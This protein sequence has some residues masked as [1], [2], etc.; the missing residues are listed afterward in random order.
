MKLI[1]LNPLILAVAAVIA[2]QANGAVIASSNF[3]GL[4]VSG[5]NSVAISGVNGFSWTRGPNTGFTYS[6]P[7]VNMQSGTAEALKLTTTSSFQGMYGTMASSTTIAIGQTLT[8]SFIG[9]YTETPTNTGGG[10]RFGFISNY[11]SGTNANADQAVGMQVGTGGS[12]ALSLNRDTTVNNGAF[13]GTTVAMG[14]GGTLSSTI[15]T[16]VFTASFS[17]LRTGTSTYTYTGT[18]NGSTATAIGETNG[19]TNYNA[20]G[21]TNGNN[22]ADFQIDNLSVTLIPEPSAVLLGGLGLLTLLRRRR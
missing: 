4:N 15:G 16:S 8:L 13:G 22:A 2:G 7:N 10:F 3:T 11:N 9:Q 19:Y 6:T 20:I 21:F 17:I 14:S 1:K 5:A 18:V 12:T